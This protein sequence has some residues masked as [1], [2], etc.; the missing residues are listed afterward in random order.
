[1]YVEGYISKLYSL[2]SHVSLPS[3]RLSQ[4]VSMNNSILVRTGE[5]SKKLAW[6]SIFNFPIQTSLSCQGDINLICRFSVLPY[7]KIF[8]NDC[9]ITDFKLDVMAAWTE[10]SK[11]HT[12]RKC[13]YQRYR[14]PG[15]YT[16]LVGIS[17]IEV[18]ICTM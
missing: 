5:P 15:Y 1:M 2:S 12:G 11:F 13:P 16:I 8:L 17:F 14:L 7:F 9:F 6:M 3:L 10:I 4:V 18:I